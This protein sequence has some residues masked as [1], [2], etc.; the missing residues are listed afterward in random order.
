V[1][2]GLNTTFS[3][4]NRTM[5]SAHCN[6]WLQSQSP[7]YCAAT[8]KLVRFCGAPSVLVELDGHMQLDLQGGLQ[9]V[10]AEI[11]PVL[12]YLLPCALFATQC[13]HSEWASNC[14]LKALAFASCTEDYPDSDIAVSFYCVV[15]ATWPSGIL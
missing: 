5:C 1:G 6:V 9:L 11:R 15:Q 10:H 7:C 4:L 2:E 13:V 14:M 3:A 12:F 8:S